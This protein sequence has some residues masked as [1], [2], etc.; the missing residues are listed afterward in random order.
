MAP[1]PEASS[2]CFSVPTEIAAWIA[3][4]LVAGVTFA[5]RLAGAMLMSRVT[6]SRAVE[7][8]LN[9]LSVSVIA[10]L[11]ASIVAQGDLRDA[12]AVALTS[13]VMLASRRAV[14]AM[15]AG[16]AL[17]AAWASRLTA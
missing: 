8:F 17:A 2:R 11:V 3:I 1:L 5:S 16:M 4:L 15:V 7:R 13:L 9:G 14:W 12:A 10:A 6:P